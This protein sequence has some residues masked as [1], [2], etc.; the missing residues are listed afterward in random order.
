MDFLKETHPM[1][2]IVVIVLHMGLTVIKTLDETVE[3]GKIFQS[4]NIILSVNSILF[5]C[6]SYELCLIGLDVMTEVC[7]LLR[8]AHMSSSITQ[9]TCTDF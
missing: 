8:V 5:Y 3:D 1:T 9:V 4:S 7:P 2:I 6:H